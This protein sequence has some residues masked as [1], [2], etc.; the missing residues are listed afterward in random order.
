MHAIYSH[1]NLR[2][3]LTRHLPEPEL[4]LAESMRIL[5]KHNRCHHLKLSCWEAAGAEVGDEQL[6]ANAAERSSSQQ[7][8]VVLSLVSLHLYSVKYTSTI[9]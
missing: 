1:L 5:P 2:D 6:V 3:K 7:L 9:S 8:H 4:G